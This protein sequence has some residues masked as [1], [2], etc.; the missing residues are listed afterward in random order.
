MSLSDQKLNEILKKIIDDYGRLLDENGVLSFVR[1]ED[2]MKKSNTDVVMFFDE[3]AELEFA[4]KFELDGALVKVFIYDDR[5]AELLLE[6][7]L[8]QDPEEDDEA[9]HRK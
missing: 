7:D 3:N 6:V 2:S 5:Q 9:E 8:S 1:P 4:L